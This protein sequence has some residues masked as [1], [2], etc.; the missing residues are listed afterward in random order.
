MPTAFTFSSI[1]DAPFGDHTSARFEGDNF[2]ALGPNPNKDPGLNFLWFD[3][4]QKV[5]RAFNGSADKLLPMRTTTSVGAVL[6]QSTA[7]FANFDVVWT[8]NATQNPMPTV[9]SVLYA[10]QINCLK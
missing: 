10:S 5:L 7:I 9:P 3:T 6:T 4:K 8:E 1:L 2:F